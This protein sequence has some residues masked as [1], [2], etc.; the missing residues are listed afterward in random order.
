[1]GERITPAKATA[2][3]ANNISDLPNKTITEMYSRQTDL[4]QELTTEDLKAL[5]KK[6]AAAGWPCGTAEILQV[7]RSNASSNH[8]KDIIIE[9]LQ[10]KAEAPQPEPA[11]QPSEPPEEDKA[12]RKRRRSKKSDG[13]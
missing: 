4:S 9:H 11:H 8:W 3:R 2:D 6:F 5:A 1:M 7:A 10:G 13:E 12:P